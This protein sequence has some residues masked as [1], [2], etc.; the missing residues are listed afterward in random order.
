MGRRLGALAPPVTFADKNNLIRSKYHENRSLG[1]GKRCPHEEKPKS[2]LDAKTRIE[3]IPL[4]ATLFSL[5][6]PSYEF[7]HP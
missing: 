6:A 7:A 5:R 4:L 1:A 3:G 2:G